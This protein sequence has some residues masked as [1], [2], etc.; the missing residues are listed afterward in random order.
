M[1]SRTLGRTDVRVSEVA[2]GTWGLAAGSYGPVA[3]QQLERTVARALDAGVT[4]F[5]CAPCWGE[6][7]ASERQV[8]KGLGERRRD[9]VLITRAGGEIKDGV[10][11]KRFDPDSLRR[12][13]EQS[14]VRLGA[15]AID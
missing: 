15:D 12:D 9:A 10:L 3:P 5:D 13:C 2:L 6:E 1:H 7:G 4:T 8:A 14:L 11:R